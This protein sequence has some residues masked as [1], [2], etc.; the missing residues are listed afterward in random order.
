MRVRAGRSTYPKAGIGFLRGFT[1]IPGGLRAPT[2]LTMNQKVAGSSP[3]ERAPLCPANTA[4][5]CGVVTSERIV[6]PWRL[7][8]R[9]NVM[10]LSACLSSSR[11]VGVLGRGKAA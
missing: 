7:T 9:V 2:M 5:Y 3:A 6:A 4:F 1:G 11:D 8:K 10:Q